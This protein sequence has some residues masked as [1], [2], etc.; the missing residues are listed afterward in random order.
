MEWA[1]SNIEFKNQQFSTGNTFSIILKRASQGT[2]ILAL[3][4]LILS[5]LSVFI[6]EGHKHNLCV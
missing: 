2:I 3:I 4:K 1:Y 6:Y 5:R